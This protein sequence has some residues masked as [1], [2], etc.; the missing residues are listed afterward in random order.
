MQWS[1]LSRGGLLVALAPH[2]CACMH[3]CVCAVSTHCL[4]CMSSFPYKDKITDY[5][6]TAKEYFGDNVIDF[7]LLSFTP[8][9]NG[10]EQNIIKLKANRVQGS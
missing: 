5:M 3:A 4:L 1:P 9:L 8:I 6:Y 2:W 10:V 7:Y